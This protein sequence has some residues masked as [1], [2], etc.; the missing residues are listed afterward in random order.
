MTYYVFYVISAWDFLEKPDKSQLLVRDLSDYH[1]S[2]HYGGSASITADII[3]MAADV[4]VSSDWWRYSIIYKY[5]SWSNTCYNCIWIIWLVAMGL[6]VIYQ[7]VV[8]GIVQS[9][10]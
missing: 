10:S 1:W 8:S 7:H 9:G 2:S 4:V 3:V 5:F 6:Y